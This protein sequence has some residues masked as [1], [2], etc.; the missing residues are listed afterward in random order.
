MS[1]TY[2]IQF[3]ENCAVVYTHEIELTEDEMRE[4]LKSQHGDDLQTIEAQMNDEDALLD[5]IKYAYPYA[6]SALQEHG[7]YRLL[8]QDIDQRYNNDCESVTIEEK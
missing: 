6:Y 7:K 2:K 8:D 5:A 3:E 1:K 4:Y